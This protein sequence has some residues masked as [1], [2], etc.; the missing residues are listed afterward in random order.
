MSMFLFQWS[1]LRD[2]WR[3]EAGWVVTC[4]L[5]L[6]AV[7]KTRGLLSMKKVGW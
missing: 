1:L 5:T 6:G 4:G 3:V 7:D 2:T